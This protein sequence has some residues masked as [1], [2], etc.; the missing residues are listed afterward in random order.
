[1]YSKL[2]LF[3]FWLIACPLLAQ[4]TKYL[5]HKDAAL[6]KKALECY[7]KGKIEFEKE[8]TDKAQQSFVR[9]LAAAPTFIDAQILLS[10]TYYEQ[11][12]YTE[13]VAE[14]QKAIVLDSTYLAYRSLYSMAKYYEKQNKYNDAARYFERFAAQNKTE[15]AEKAKYLAANNRFRAMAYLHPVPFKPVNMGDE[16]NSTYAEYLPS[17]TADGQ[18]LIFTKRIDNQEDFYSSNLNSGFWTKASPLPSPIN[19]PDNEGAQT[20]SADGKLLVYTG[21]SRVGGMGSCDL[22]FSEYKSGKWSD[23][24]NMGAPVNSRDW[25]SQPSL[26]ADGSMLIFTSSRKDGKNEGKNLFYTTRNEKGEWATPKGI[27]ELNTPYDDCSPFLHPDGQ[28]LYFASNGHPGFGG[29]DVFI[30]RKQPSGVWGKPENLGTPIN[31]EKDEGCMIFS[32]DGKKAIYAAEFADTHGKLDLYT[33]DVPLNLRPQPVTY[34]KAKIQNAVTQKPLSGVE[35]ILTDLTTNKKITT[36]Y[37]DE[38]GSVLVC[39]PSGANYGVSIAAKGYAFY[40]DNFELTDAHSLD[41][42]FVATVNLQPINVT[43]NTNNPLPSGSTGKPIV[44]KNVFFASGS[45]DLKPE[46]RTE[47]N[48]LKDLLAENPGLKIQINGHTDNVGSDATNLTLSENRANS[49]KNFLIQNG[50]STFR[51]TAKGFGKQA[52]IDT[53]DTDAGR[54]NNRRTEFL[55]L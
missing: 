54:K 43:A 42:P 28:T 35:L 13:A 41:K 37:S 24:L 33:F 10:E 15:K 49:V 52:P 3:A 20:I 14:L 17:M 19:T 22:Y 34:Y 27:G 9:A 11:K 6:P 47:L 39:L 50:I 29:N 23:P 48:K 51:L 12:K 31:T 38:N 4:N 7:Q 5:T 2:L 40:S 32:L 1:M 44:L 25:E 30:S 8:Q 55:I 18:T 53:N 36:K 21:C 46:S 16:I 26:S 45:A